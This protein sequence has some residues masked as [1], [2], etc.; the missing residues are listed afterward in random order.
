[1]LWNC[2]LLTKKEVGIF[3]DNMCREEQNSLGRIC[4]LTNTHTKKKRRL[5]SMN[6]WRFFSKTRAREGTGLKYWESLRSGVNKTWER[7]GKMLVGTVVVLLPLLQRASKS[8]YIE[9]FL[10]GIDFNILP[11]FRCLENWAFFILL[12]K[13][14]CVLPFQHQ[15]PKFTQ[16]IF[17][18]SV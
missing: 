13:V 14:R 11:Q 6:I 5:P 18:K 16:I 2:I 9:H 17:N 8:W 12:N 15:T 4:I 7:R 3:T 10:L 1:M